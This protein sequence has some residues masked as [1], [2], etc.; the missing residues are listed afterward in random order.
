MAYVSG[1]LLD[2]CVNPERTGFNLP[3]EGELHDAGELTE[4]E[5][6]RGT[7]ESIRRELGGELQSLQE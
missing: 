4:E 1:N 6:V 2:R 3:H 5:I 7:L